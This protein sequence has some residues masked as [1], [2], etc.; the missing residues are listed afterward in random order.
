[1]ASEIETTWSH[2][3]VLIDTPSG[4]RGTGFLVG[5]PAGE[6]QWKI[7]LVTNKHVLHPEKKKRDSID[8]VRLHI[9]LTKADALVGE[10]VDYSMR[11]KG[12]SIWRE[13]PDPDVD[14][15]AVTQ[16]AFAKARP[17]CLSCARGSSRH[18]SERNSTRRFR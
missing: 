7:F 15:L 11:E 14:V 1:M 12:V 16:V 10:V 9:N 6:D 13:H 2:T 3:T 8:S 4:G 17:I 18:A 5:R